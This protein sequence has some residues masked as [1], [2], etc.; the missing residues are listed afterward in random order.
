MREGGECLLHLARLRLRLA[1]RDVEEVQVGVPPQQLVEDVHRL[2][3]PALAHERERIPV[4]G[5]QTVIAVGDPFGE[6]SLHVLIR[7]C[8][9]H[10]DARLDQV[11]VRRAGIRYGRELCGVCARVGYPVGGHGVTDEHRRD[12]GVLQA[13]QPH[14]FLEDIGHAFG[15]EA[16][17]GQ[18]LEA[19]AVGL[20][21]HA[22][23]VVDLFLGGEP[24]RGDDAAGDGVAAAACRPEQD[25]RQHGGEG[26]YVGVLGVEELAGDVVLDLVRGLV[27]HHRRELRLRMGK[28]NQA[29]VDEDIVARG[30][31]GVDYRR[32]D[33]EV[34]KAGRA[35][36]ALRREPPAD[37]VQVLLDLGVLYELMLR[38]HL[39]HHLVADLVLL[40]HRQDDRSRT[41]E[42]RQVRF[43]RRGQIG[44]QWNRG[45]RGRG[46]EFGRLALV[47]RGQ[48]GRWRGRRHAGSGHRGVHEGGQQKPDER[49]H[50]NWTS[51][52]GERFPCE[53]RSLQI[54]RH[55]KARRPGNKLTK[56]HWPQ[57]LSEAKSASRER[58][59][60]I[61]VT[62]PECGQPR[63]RL[64]A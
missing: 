17:G 54:F 36:R 43:E 52:D 27:G 44:G 45:Q 35:E 59:P 4:Q 20:L 25:R 34:V 40:L 53:Y 31:E 29:G 49:A 14:Q 7:R 63:K 32:V 30:R 5:A 28:Q 18:K 41:A 6:I 11:V 9:E 51:T 56:N 37:G 61:N 42:I 46:D 10:P 33:A 26:I 19:D 62:C 55:R 23:A 3:R 16:G 21:F 50:V 15:V 12:P 58:S 60:R 64:T 22:A 13:L 24:L 39:Q 48:G 47:L 8:G 38:A 2:H 1:E 57:R